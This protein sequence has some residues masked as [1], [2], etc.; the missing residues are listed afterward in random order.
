MTI[1]CHKHCPDR[2]VGCHSSCERY[3][4]YRKYLD[5]RSEAI[6]QEKAIYGYK[7]IKKRQMDK[8]MLKTFSKYCSS[9]SYD[10]KR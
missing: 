1:P 8:K 10:R 2:A 5:E 4:A 9:N 6:R 7:S 3:K